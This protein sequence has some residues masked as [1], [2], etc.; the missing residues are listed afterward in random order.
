MSEIGH[1][2]R[3]LF[4]RVFPERQIY[5]RS[6][7]TVRYISLSPHKQAAMAL[8]AAG[9]AGWCIYATANMMLQGPVTAGNSPETQRQIASYE[10]MLTEAQAQ[11]SA[12]QAQM[13]ERTREY[14]QNMREFERRH[15]ALAYLVEF[16][17]GSSVALAREALDSDGARMINQASIDE[18]DP[19]QSRALVEPGARV[20]AIG[21]RAE[22]D[23]LQ[24]QQ[25]LALASLEN[26]LVEEADEIRGVLR[27]TGV[28]VSR[29]TEEG[30]AE[31][32]VDQDLV[33]YLRQGS[34]DTA[35]ARRVEQVAARVAEARGLRSVI[36]SAPLGPP[37]GVDHR[38]T[39]GYGPRID[40]FTG[41]T[42]FHNG[43][44]FAA[45][46]RAPVT[47]S[48]SGR[49][50]YVGWMGGYGNVVEIDH[51]NQFRTRYAHLAGFDVR[52]GDQV[53]Q[54]TRV[55]SMGSTGRSTGTHLHYEV[56]HR[57]RTV[58]PVN[59]IRAGRYVHEQ[60]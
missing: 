57:G 49:V 60:G 50:S 30:S 37:V 3:A 1:R 23:G 29:L 8:G 41:R 35:F 51:G 2:A 9:V 10:R 16:A 38:E 6:G 31:A 33:D 27:L 40:P 14:E 18:A 19:R 58:D 39:S 36:R 4:D 42:A 53:E 48:A 46:D 5:H 15:D 20:Q 21:F 25:E 54:G 52:V 32:A 17:S 59:F 28:S 43:L 47:A 45:F 34:V 26:A 24:S 11:N 7:G 13:D 44:D 22:T 56:F 12:M 55:G